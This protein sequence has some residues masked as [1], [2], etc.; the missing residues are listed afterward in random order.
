MN[1]V[2]PNGSFP[3]LNNMSSTPNSPLDLGDFH[4][5]PSNLNE[6]PNSPS[7][8]L[9]P[10]LSPL[11]LTDPAPQYTPYPNMNELSDYVQKCVANDMVFESRNEFVVHL[12]ALS[13]KG[14][15][16][17]PYYDVLYKESGDYL[18]KHY[19]TAKTSRSRYGPA[20]EYAVRASNNLPE[21]KKICVAISDAHANA[22]ETEMRKYFNAEYKNMY[23]E[24][25][26]NLASL[27][28][29]KYVGYK[30]GD[31]AFCPRGSKYIEEW[32]TGIYRILELREDDLFDLNEPWGGRHLVKSHMKKQIDKCDSFNELFGT[33]EGKDAI[34]KELKKLVIKN[35]VPLAPPEPANL[36]ELVEIVKS[37]V[38][39]DSRAKVS[40]SEVSV[41]SKRAAATPPS[42]PSAKRQRVTREEFEKM[43]AKVM[44]LKEHNQQIVNNFQ[45]QLQSVVAH[46][47]GEIARL[48]SQITQG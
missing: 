15:F 7:L 16:K 34:L 35:Q 32:I 5:D 4:L 38:R 2:L 47:K 40:K 42:E 25:E 45:T 3:I 41:G 18:F 19:V 30:Q 12:E 44:K 21:L 11:P 46:F 8:N 27:N 20:S 22:K 1:H 31:Q 23:N 13:E 14:K 26:K 10:P 43:E 6:E 24:F 37:K 48:E 17:T 36:A 33:W 29:P 28:I 9:D 39:E